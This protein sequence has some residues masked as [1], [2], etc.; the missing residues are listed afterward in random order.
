MRT[1]AT[2]KLIEAIYSLDNKKDIEDF[3]YFLCSENEIMKLAGRIDL[4]RRVLNGETYRDISANVNA[5]SSTVSRIKT[6]LNNENSVLR[7]VIERL[8]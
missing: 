5:A 4:A 8:K 2:D 3:F 6:V 1:E 7:S